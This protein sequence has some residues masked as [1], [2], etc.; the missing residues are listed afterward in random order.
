MKRDEMWYTILVFIVVGGIIFALYMEISSSEK[1]DIR[2]LSSESIKAQELLKNLQKRL[3]KVEQWQS[4]FASTFKWTP[5][6]DKLPPP[7]PLEGD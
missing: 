6:I 5:P 1:I 3:D 7:E 2:A 4:Q